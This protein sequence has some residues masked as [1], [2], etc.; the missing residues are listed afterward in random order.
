MP[1]GAPPPA[2]PLSAF[3]YTDAITRLIAD[4]VTRVEALK[5]IDPKRVL[6]FASVAKSAA[7][8]WSLMACHCLCGPQE[9]GEATAD[10]PK[11]RHARRDWEDRKLPT[12]TIAEQ[13]QDYMLNVGLPW[14]C[15]FA[16]EASSRSNPGVG[17]RS[18]KLEALMVL[19]HAMSPTGRGFRDAPPGWAT[20]EFSRR[21]SA[22]PEDREVV[23]ELVREYLASGPS[24]DVLGFLQCGFDELL[25]R[26]GAVV[27]AVFK[28]APQYPQPHRRWL[29]SGAASTRQWDFTEEDLVVRPFPLDLAA[30]AKKR[31]RSRYAEGFSHTGLTEEQRKAKEHAETRAE[32]RL[33]EDEVY[34]LESKL[35]KAIALLDRHGL[36]RKE[37]WIRHWLDDGYLEQ[38]PRRRHTR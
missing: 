7:S 21:W 16:G 15:T 37:P 38:K 19:L 8:A 23:R 13:P 25:A 10:M 36:A 1:S 24:E 20:F 14:F 34:D 26:H 11:E 2:V 3:N 18:V 27:A 12:V 32:Q 28:Q 31:R 29:R 33:L 22:L 35:W 30:D 17:A 9:V 4:I 6:V 5:H